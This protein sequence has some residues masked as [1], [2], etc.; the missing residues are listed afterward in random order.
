MS[1]ANGN[2]HGQIT[3][4]IQKDDP[5]TADFRSQGI[6]GLDHH[7]GIVHDDEYHKDLTGKQAIKTY[8]E[9]RDN[10]PIIG[11]VHFG[12]DML[13]RQ[14]PW[15][16]EPF[17]QEDRDIENAEFLQSCM[18]DMS[19]TF[20]DVISE[21][22][23]KLTFG[24][25]LME[26]LYK[27]RI[28]PEEETGS[29]FSKFTDGRVGWRK[30]ELRAQESLDHWH[31]DD[32]GGI[33]G[34]WQRAAPDYKLRYISIKKALLFRTSVY[35]NNPEGRSPLRTAYRPYYYKR[36]I[37]EIE[38][39]GI[40]RDLAGL[41]FA[42]VDPAIL[43]ENASAEEK[44]ILD[45]IRSI[46]Q[47][48]RRDAQ[49]GILFPNVYDENG[50]RLYDFELMSSG[51]GRQFDTGAIIERY[52]K[53]MAMTLMADFILLGHDSTGSFA[54]SDN[55]TSLFSVALGAWMDMDAA[56]FNRHAVSRLFRLNGMPIDRLPKIVHGDIEEADLS[57]V[58]SFIASLVA[59]GMPLFPDPTLEA[60]LRKQAG[61]PE[62]DPNAS[63]VLPQQAINA[64]DPKKVVDTSKEPEARTQ[65]P[66][67]SNAGAGVN[68]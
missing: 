20:A 37:E 29:T 41:P 52:V 18:D 12:I 10:D 51:G 65:P 30:F 67:R 53:H 13:M 16:A 5:V 19:I 21:I 43:A 56:V 63:P 45:A 15:R 46:V 59:A 14:A 7:F 22:N 34:M 4:V 25:A 26:I 6:T 44:Q 55:K 27:R 48:V 47:N 33:Q 17:S 23:S 9:M 38:G 32:D 8:K 1:D 42:R 66:Q 49:E 35:K 2:G 39:V 11:A 54:L 31:F 28:G 57:K 36:R 68:Q 62:A 61:M 40:E 24:W 60:W 3:T 50:N 58:S 64:T